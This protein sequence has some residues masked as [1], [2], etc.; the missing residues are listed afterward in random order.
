MKTQQADAMII[1]L[2]WPDVFV[3]ATGEMFDPFFKS[4]GIQKSGKY[5]AGHSAL[6]LV[7]NENGACEFFD[8]GRYI[9]PS[10]KG[11]VRGAKTDPE[12]T[13]QITAQMKDNQILNLEELLIWLE[14]N[15]E[16]T[17]GHG[18]MIASV[19]HEINYTAAKS[20]IEKEQEKG[21][22]HYSPFH[23]KATNCSRFVAD[24]CREGTV[25]KWIKVKNSVRLTVTPSPLGNVYNSRTSPT[26][27]HVKQGQI[28]EYP[29]RLS[30]VL[31][32]VLLGFLDTPPEAGPDPLVGTLEEPN[33]PTS[34]DA[35]AMWLGGIGAGVWF[36]QKQDP[37]IPDHLMKIQRIAPD[38]SVDFERI[39]ALP[40]RFNKNLTFQFV[41]DC[42]A[43]YCTVLQV[44][45]RYRL[46]VVPT[47]DLAFQ[48]SGR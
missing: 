42:N 4:L 10:G 16:I 11:R 24:A 6:V 41:Y 38:G 1:V 39:Y 2:A 5:K 3:S 12:V 37:T 31:K 32:D 20:F 23:P 18:R 45:T 44:E 30:K 48:L 21:S 22:C 36:Q 34:L 28:S 19:C 35:S 8:F 33:R 26:M 27:Y 7:K 46:D 17:H 40:K 15:E 29:S 43:H 9:T 25:S 47:S 13:I 14:A